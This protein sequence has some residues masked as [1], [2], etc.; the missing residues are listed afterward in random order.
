MR[1]SDNGV[2][3]RRSFG[4]LHDIVLV[5]PFMLLLL[6]VMYAVLP[7]SPGVHSNKHH[8]LRIILYGVLT[9]A[10]RILPANINIASGSTVIRRC[11]LDRVLLRALVVEL[12]S[13]RSE[14]LNMFAKMLC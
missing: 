5:V 14:L 13:R 9:I 4:R 3:P 12:D 6:D 1:G 2:L 11:V 8:Q 10:P 7:C